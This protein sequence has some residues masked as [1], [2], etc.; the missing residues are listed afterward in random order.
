[1][2]KETTKHDWL[3]LVIGGI[4]GIVLGAIAIVFFYHKFNTLPTTVTGIT[5]F[6]ILWT[7]CV[8]YKY[9]KTK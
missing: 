3:I 5:L 1:M 2:K 4:I 6:N 9:I 7:V 8:L